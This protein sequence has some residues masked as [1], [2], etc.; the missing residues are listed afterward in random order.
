MNDWLSIDFLKNSTTFYHIV[1]D[2]E[3]RYLYVNDYF[4]RKFGFVE[5]QLI[6]SSF[7]NSVYHQDVERCNQ[8]ARELIQ[9][10][11]KVISIDIRK[12]KP[13]GDF[14]WTV[15]EFSMARDPAGNPIGI[16]CIG[17]DITPAQ[18]ARK[19]LQLYTERVK[20]LMEIDQRRKEEIR[21]HITNLPDE[22]KESL[23]GIFGLLQV[24]NFEDYQ[25]DFNKIVI[26]K[27]SEYGEMLDKLIFG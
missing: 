6:G 26:N 14:F 19:E 23:I 5:K 24:F 11:D 22:V 18:K 20:K 1:T 9:H 7:T 16:R 17:F 25:D 10:P 21:S 15:W 27:L 3:G 8:A 12:P 13:D 4:L 2:L